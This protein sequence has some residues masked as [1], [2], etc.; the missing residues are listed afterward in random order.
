MTTLL[1]LMDLNSRCLA[2]A[3]QDLLQLVVACRHA[4]LH[5]GGQDGVARRLRVEQD[6][7]RED[8]LAALF[9]QHGRNHGFTWVDGLIEP[10][11]VHDALWAHDLAIGTPHPISAP[12]RSLRN[13]YR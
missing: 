9:R 6:P 8:G 13:T 1:T 2:L 12:F 3:L 4:P 10:L 11:G 7:G 5:A